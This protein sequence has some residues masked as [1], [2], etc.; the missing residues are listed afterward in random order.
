MFLPKKDEWLLATSAIHPP[1]WREKT[2]G[3]FC[4]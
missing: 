4:I 3:A 2:T 1:N